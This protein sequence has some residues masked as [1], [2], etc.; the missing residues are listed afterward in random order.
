MLFVVDVGKEG[1][2]GM[3]VL[4]GEG[5][6]FVIVALRAAHGGSHPDGRDIADAVGLINGAVFFFLKPAFVSGLKQAIIAGGD[7]LVF[8]GVWKEIAGELFSGELVEGLVLVEGIDD[9]IAIGRDPLILITVVSHGVGVADE[10]EPINGHAFTEMWR[11]EEEID[12]SLD[13]GLRSNLVGCFKTAK[14]VGLWWK[15]GEVKMEP[16]E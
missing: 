9:V 14:V 12:F 4:G 8:G 11:G 5:I 6:V 13:G 3:E 2:Q 1:S 16:S 10:I 15:S 7:A